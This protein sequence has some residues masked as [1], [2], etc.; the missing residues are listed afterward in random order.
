MGTTNFISHRQ[1]RCF[2]V[3]YTI[4]GQA[5]EIYVWGLSMREVVNNLFTELQHQYKDC[6]IEIEACRQQNPPQE[7]VGPIGEA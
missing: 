7:S 1:V 4:D 6:E 2:V 5:F 3:F